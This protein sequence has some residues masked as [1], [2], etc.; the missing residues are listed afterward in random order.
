V[1]REP[2][3]REQIVRFCQLLHQKGYLAA[4][5]G[6]ISVRL[7]QHRLLV[8]PT[9][10]PKAFLNPDELVVV[11]NDGQ[12]LSGGKPSGELS[13]HLHALRGRP[14]MEA[15]VHAHPPTSIALTLFRHLRINGVLP[16]VTLS[17]GEIEIV[18]YARP[19]TEE[20]AC[21]VEEATRRHDAVI[22][23]RH[24][25]VTLGKT[26][27]DAYARTERLE[28]A[29]QVLWLAHAIGRPPGLP[30]HEARTLMKLYE[31]GRNQTY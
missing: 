25:T 30:E 29:A 17:I 27:S 9:G 22:L 20:L 1:S 15:V 21:A 28:H 24:G 3:L 14:D 6:N 2:E 11:D 19:L 8:T 5:D 7:C 23:E 10:V 31:R 26:V 18:P 13:M 4:N 16:E 12:V